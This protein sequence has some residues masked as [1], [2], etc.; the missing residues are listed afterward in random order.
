[1]RISNRIPRVCVLTVAL[2]V[3]SSAAAIAADTVGVSNP[4][5]RATVA[6]QEVAGAYMDITARAPVALIAVESPLAAKAELH[7]MAIEGGVMKMRPLE[8]LDL[9]ANQTVSLKP[10]GHHVMLIGIRRMLKPGEHV[11]L[12]LTLQ[13]QKGVKSTLQVEAAVRAVIGGSANQNK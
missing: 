1:M 3:I 6:G 12:K 2:A 13:D 11:A 8:K 9:P 5:V 7:M 10:S 4:W